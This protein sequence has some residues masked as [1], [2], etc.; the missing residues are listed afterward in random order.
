[1]ATP[2]HLIEPVED[3]L[4]QAAETYIE[5]AER[6]CRKNNI[7]SKK[8]VRAGHPVEEIIKEAGASKADLIIMGSH[9]KSAMKAAVLGS[10]T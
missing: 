3:Y 1:M 10:I 5:E 6:L 2:T 8:A 4:K 7:Q 9:G